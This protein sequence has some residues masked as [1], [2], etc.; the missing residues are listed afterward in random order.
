MIDKKIFFTSLLLVSVFIS[1]IGNAQDKR[2][3]LPGFLSRTSLTLNIGYINY[4]FSQ[5]QLEPGFYSSSIHTPHVGVNLAVLCYRLKQNLEVN[6]RYMRPVNWVQYKNVNGDQSFHS[7]FLNWLAL[8]AKS[9]I[10]L[11]ENLRIYGEAGPALFTRLATLKQDSVILKGATYLTALAGAGVEYAVNKKWT[12]RAGMLYSPSNKKAKQPNTIF[13]AG[14][15]TFNV[16]PLPEAKVLRNS[17]SGYIFP[18]HQLL[19]SYTNNF[20]GYGVNRFFGEGAVPVFWTGDIRISKG[21]AIQYQQNIYHSRKLFSLDWGSS[22]SFWQSKNDKA[23]FFTLSVFPV[24]RF[25]LLRT[26]P[27]DFYFDYSAAGPSY[28]SKVNIDNINSGKHFTF[29]DYMGVGFFAGKQRQLN[30]GIKIQHYS[31][32]NIFTANPGLQIPLTFNAGYNF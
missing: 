17:N 28:I 18:H 32:G 6:L 5:S 19:I 22:L 23:H 9:G 13:I 31:N 25:T 1:L 11:N 3:Q 30:A 2:A 27:F 8:T 7:V 26:K 24:F 14:G 29:Q 20:A 21:F 10:H 12:L 15:A 16:S 4:P